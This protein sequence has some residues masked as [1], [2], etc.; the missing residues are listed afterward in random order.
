[1]ATTTKTEERRGN[2]TVTVFEKNDAGLFA[3]R[4]KYPNGLLFKVRQYCRIYPMQ[5]GQ[6]WSAP[7]PYS[8]QEIRDGCKRNI[9]SGSSAIIYAVPAAEMSYRRELLKYALAAI[10]PSKKWYGNPPKLDRETERALKGLGVTV[11]ADGTI[12]RGPSRMVPFSPPPLV[13]PRLAAVVIS[14]KAEF[15]SAIRSHFRE[16]ESRGLPH[17]E[18]NSGQLHKKVGGYPGPEARMPSCC[19]AMY[20]EQ[21]AGDEVISRSARGKGA[22]LTI[23]YHLPRSATSTS[24]I[25]SQERPRVD[26]KAPRIIRVPEVVDRPRPT[27]AG[28]NFEHISTVKPLNQWFEELPF[29]LA[30]I[31]RAWQATPVQDFKTKYEHLLH[32]FEATA[33]FVSVIMLSAFSSKEELFAPHKQRLADEMR[34][35]NLSFPR[36]TFGTWKL[37]A[38]YLGKQTRQLLASDEKTLALCADLFSDPSLRLPQALSR[39][40]FTAILSTTNK[41]NKMRNDWGGH[42][43]VV[44]QE[45]SPP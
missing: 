36:A 44:G 43:G 12:M 42:G 6:A 10:N 22:S 4:D 38:E 20:N 37:V 14:T 25:P 31:Y 34:R 40:D 8:D 1:M 13:P 17:I 24:E 7:K 27:V 26:V 28:H 11:R 15:R 21:Q 32:L 41:T 16:A 2:A 30:S 23:R 9:F 33:E 29:P 18:I 19:Q 3:Y 35:Q 45:E 5:D 39:K